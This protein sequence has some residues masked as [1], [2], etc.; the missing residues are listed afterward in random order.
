MWSLSI[1]N[2]VILGQ[3]LTTMSCLLAYGKKKSNSAHSFLKEVRKNPTSF[4]EK[5]IFEPK[6]NRCLRMQSFTEAVFPQ[7]SAENT[8]E[9]CS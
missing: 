5:R 1:L 3:R 6:S 9:P 7:R 8:K 4:V 2:D